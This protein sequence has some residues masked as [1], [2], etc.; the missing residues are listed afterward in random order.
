VKRAIIVHAWE[1]SPD[2]HWYQEEK[3]LLE[4]MG[5]SVSVPVL[6]G[7]L[8]PKLPEWLDIIEEFKPDEDTILIGH[9]LGVPAIF[10]Y[11]ERSGQKVSEVISVAGFASDLG[12]DET[13][14]FIDRVFDWDKIRKLA[15]KVVVIAQKDDPYIPIVVSEEVAIKT[16]GK[17]H[18]VEGNNHFDKM[19]LKLINDNL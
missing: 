15:G 9:S 16:E 12:M 17:L 3:E 4:E 7:G 8:W 13:R 18:L 5:Y 19:D 11:L 14:N 6:P 10:R 1:S 2:Q